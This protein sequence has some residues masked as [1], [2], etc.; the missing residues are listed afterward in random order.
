VTAAMVLVCAFSVQAQRRG[1]RRN[2]IPEPSSLLDSVKA[3]QCSFSA[4]ST[5]R[6]ENGMA[7]VQTS[8]LP[9]G[10]RITIEQIDVQGGTAN[11]VTGF[12]RGDDVNVRL[13]G[14]NLHFL[15]VGPDGALGVVTVFAQETQDGRLQA[16][17]SRAAYPEAAQYYG[18]CVAD[19]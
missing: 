6:W 18:D 1:R 19:R 12:R 2:R 16:V 3:L 7:K 14:S 4:G 13:V 9:D 17:Y 11:I 8:T 5:A 15:D 10:G